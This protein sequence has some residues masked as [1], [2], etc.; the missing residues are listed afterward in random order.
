L[1]G[2][3]DIT[4]V[5]G[6][7]VVSSNWELIRAPGE[8]CEDQAAIERVRMEIPRSAVESLG[9]GVEGHGVQIAMSMK[10][11]GTIVFGGCREPAAAPLD[12]SE[13]LG[14]SP[15]VPHSPTLCGLT[16]VP[17]GFGTPGPSRA[18]PS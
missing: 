18:G 14:V 16:P 15:L 5:I 11:P 8:P 13:H 2:T 7:P 4:A 12:V 9:T 17:D 6:L 10:S 1:V 3:P